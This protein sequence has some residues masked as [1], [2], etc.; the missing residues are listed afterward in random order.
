MNPKVTVYITNFNYGQYLE[1]AI[2]SVLDQTFQDFEFLIIDDGSKDNSMDIIKRFEK[3]E[4]VFLVA[5]KNKGLNVSNNIAL[6]MARGKYFMR[7][8]ADDYLDPH[9][10]EVMV[11]V[12]EK[13]IELSL[14][15]PDYYEVDENG[16]ILNQVR[17]HDFANDV[18]LL[19]Q[20][21]H[22]ACTMI[23][24]KVLFEVGGYDESFNKQDGYDL[25]FKVIDDYKVC[26]INL[27][28]FYYRKHGNS[29]SS[30][31]KELL[32]V[33]ARI[34]KER[35]KTKGIKPISVLAIV[36][37]RGRKMDPRS[38]PLEKLGDKL[39][40][41]WTL[42][43]AL[44]SN[45]LTDV[46]VT[47]PDKDVIRHVSDKY[48]GAIITIERLA[49]LA[50]INTGFE[51]TIIESLERYEESHSLMDAVMVLNINSPFKKKMYLEKAIHTFQLHGVD[52]VRSMII[53]DGYFYEHDG[54]GL[55]P[56]NHNNSS[57]RLERTNLYR[58]AGGIM[59]IR[60]SIINT[61]L[62]HNKS[63]GHIIIDQDSAF[64]INTAFDFKVAEI[65]SEK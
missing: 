22:G 14:V 12:M 50:R 15:F 3:I 18:K 9:C 21:A 46:L 11:S 63:N 62:F 34:K 16:E 41:D 51:Q 7:L 8:D 10:L 39:L 60:R 37:I 65:L 57:L 17:R 4:N 13:D 31:D 52:T 35:V 2:K 24:T 27:P 6:R 38:F 56:R 61:E 48:A 30:D 5:Q 64:V 54:S 42:D 29:L 36:P 20:P 19:D 1:Q 25:W 45:L 58:E 49:K 33:R 59:L 23:R 47:T 44:K 43:S 32:K 40:I 53:D 26:N 55:K 28:L